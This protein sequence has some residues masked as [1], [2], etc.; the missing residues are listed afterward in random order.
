MIRLS[1]KW[2]IRY[3]RKVNLNTQQLCS[4]ENESSLQNLAAMYR[5]LNI[6]E[7]LR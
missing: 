3:C 4:S 2:F 6:L 7:T 1:I 5:D